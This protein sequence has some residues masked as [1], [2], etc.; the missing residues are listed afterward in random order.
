MTAPDVW[1]DLHPED[2]I[3]DAKN[4]VRCAL[5]TL[6]AIDGFRHEADNDRL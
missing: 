1:R 5:A 2:V 4:E 3:L 6:A